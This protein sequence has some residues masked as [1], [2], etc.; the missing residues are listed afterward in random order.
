MRFNPTE[1][2][3]SPSTTPRFRLNIGTLLHHWLDDWRERRF[4]V[5][6]KATKA[7]LNAHLLQDIGH[8]D[9]P[10]ACGRNSE[11]CK[12]GIRAFNMQLLRTL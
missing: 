6:S 10:P 8:D 9:V 5:R 11:R 1:K 4:Q 2:G 3:M 12:A 7:E